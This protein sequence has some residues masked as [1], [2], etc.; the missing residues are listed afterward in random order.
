ML[1]PVARRRA[2]TSRVG[3]E[4][5]CGICMNQAGQLE[6]AGKW[7]EGGVETTSAPSITSR[8]GANGLLH[9]SNGREPVVF[10][11]DCLWHGGWPDGRLAVQN[12]EHSWNYWPLC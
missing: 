7:T 8:Y 12:G 3:E 6:V 1:Q 4:L 10:T 9:S 5:Y 2:N 11:T